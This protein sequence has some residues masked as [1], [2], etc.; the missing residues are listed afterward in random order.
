MI[1][2]KMYPQAFPFL[3]RLSSKSTSDVQLALGRLSN[4]SVI[5]LFFLLL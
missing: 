3:R 5:A 4:G 2:H 1:S